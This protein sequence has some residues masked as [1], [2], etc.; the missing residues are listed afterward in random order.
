M[1]HY[2]EDSL[3]ATQSIISITTV[4]YVRCYKTT[5]VLSSNSFRS[6]VIAHHSN[7]NAPTPNIHAAS[8]TM[9]P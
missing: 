5:S 3:Y 4:I 6:V 7:N 1:S 8:T 2:P 9:V